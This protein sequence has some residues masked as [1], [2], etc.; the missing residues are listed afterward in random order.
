[1]VDFGIQII[2]DSGQTQVDQNYRNL[3]LR[4]SFVGYTTTAVGK[5]IYGTPLPNS[6]GGLTSYIDYGFTKT[7]YESPIIAVTNHRLGGSYGATTI[8]GFNQDASNWYFSVYMKGDVGSAFEVFIF[9][10]PTETYGYGMKVYRGDNTLAFNSE[11]YPMRFGSFATQA[12]NAWTTGPA[13]P[14]YSPAINTDRKYAMAVAQPYIGFQTAVWSGPGGGVS[15]YPNVQTEPGHT[16]SASGGATVKQ[17]NWYLTG[18][19]QGNF[20]D[21]FVDQVAWDEKYWLP[22]SLTVNPGSP[23]GPSHGSPAAMTY[24]SATAGTYFLYDVTQYPMLS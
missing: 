23:V 5:D 14:S 11:Q 10:K 8:T 2:N 19:S 18:F 13:S 16:G 7:N 4:N 21:V 3:V 9:D 1:M 15:G 22:T 12:S 6:L 17:S 24:D 20:G